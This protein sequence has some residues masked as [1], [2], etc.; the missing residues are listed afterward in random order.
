MQKKL[1]NKQFIHAEAKIN[2]ALWALL[3][4]SYFLRLGD[5]VCNIKIQSKNKYPNREEKSLRR[6]AMVSKYL[7]LNKS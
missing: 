5:I 4:C 2:I 3:H 6:V 7:D 1:D